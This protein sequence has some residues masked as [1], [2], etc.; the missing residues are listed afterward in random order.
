MT[1]ITAVKVTTPISLYIIIWIV[2]KSHLGYHGYR[3]YD[4]AWFV[5]V[6]VRAP[7]TTP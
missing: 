5:L 7:N 4:R 1:V 2:V 6:G 3:G